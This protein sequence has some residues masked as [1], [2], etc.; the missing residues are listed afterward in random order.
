LRPPPNSTDT[1][2]I[3][4]FYNLQPDVAVQR[5]HKVAGKTSRQGRKNP[6]TAGATLLTA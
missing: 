3:T 6:V 1:F 2:V 5:A 4:A